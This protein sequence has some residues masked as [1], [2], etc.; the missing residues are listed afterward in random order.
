MQ[1]SQG[2]LT[3]SAKTQLAGLTGLRFVAALAIVFYHFFALPHLAGS[4]AWLAGIALNG[5]VGVGLFF[6]LSGFVMTY[7]YMNG[8]ATGSVSRREY[9]IARFSRIYPVYIISIGLCTPFVLAQLYARDGST[10]AIS[11]LL[12]YLGLAMSMTQSWTAIHNSSLNPPSWSVSTEVFFYLI[13]PLVAV[14]VVR[15]RTVHLM[16]VL[17][18]A[19]ITALTAATVYLILNPDGVGVV[20]LHANSSL[21]LGTTDVFWGTVL[22]HNPLFRLPDFLV[23]VVTGKLFLS[24]NGLDGGSRQRYLPGSGVTAL[25]A[26][27]G[28][29]RLL[30][31]IGTELPP[32]FANALLLPLFAMLIFSIA[33]GGGPVGWCLSRPVVVLL[34]NASYAVYILQ[35]PLWRIGISVTKR[36][37]GT[38]DAVET[39]PYFLAFTIVLAATS[40][41]SLRLLEQPARRW[42]KQVLDSR[43]RKSI[44]VPGVA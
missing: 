1:L 17:G 41:L 24:V 27:G 44:N 23:G 29:L 2:T 38:L 43:P 19:W 7:T 6:V 4:P 10:A 30:A 16:L 18:C 21:W 22:A 28:I 39:W 15:L 20:N 26:L 32:L 35:D 3:G 11:E 14:A 40:M 9:W 5:H 42:L 34:G 8:L 36:V 25:A 13:F 33:R 31:A 12:G 37:A